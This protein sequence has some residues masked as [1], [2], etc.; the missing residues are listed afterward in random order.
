[1]MNKKYP[2]DSEP[3]GKGGGRGGGGAGSIVCLLTPV[4]GFP[5]HPCVRVGAVLVCMMFHACA[6]SACI[7]YVKRKGAGVCLHERECVQRW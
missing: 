6:V 2:S 5:P 7:Y 4:R 3:H 1:M